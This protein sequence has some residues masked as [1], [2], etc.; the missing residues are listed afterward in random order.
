[1]S[2]HIILQDASSIPKANECKIA[3]F[4]ETN[5]DLTVK[6]DASMQDFFSYVGA[7]LDNTRPNPSLGLFSPTEN[8]QR[9][10][11]PTAEGQGTVKDAIDLALLK[12]NSATTR[13]S[14]NRFEI[15]KGGDRVAVISIARPAYR[16]GEAISS[17]IE[18]QES[19]ISCYSL[20]ATLESSESIDPSVAL[21]SKASILR[22]TRRVHVSH[23]ES[24]LFQQR[25][26]FSPVIPTSATPGFITSGVSL[27]WN[28]RFEF[29]TGRNRQVEGIEGENLLE[30]IAKDGRGS[31]V[32]AV[33]AL[34]CDIFDVMVPLK[35]Y[36]ATSNFDEKIETGDLP[37]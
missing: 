2:P 23:S 6:H 18:F 16:L 15:T 33:Q 27:E 37:I 25:A 19:D 1:M 12:S 36:G 13:R 31:V 7:A 21:R 11:T 26:I 20:H 35:V 8:G 29:V 10:F 32:A 9:L 24:T 4:D 34:S 28:L 22:A 17:V 3:D 5:S 30:E 14:A